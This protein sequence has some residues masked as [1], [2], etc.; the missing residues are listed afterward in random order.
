[1]QAAGVFNQHFIIFQVF[2]VAGFVASVIWI[3]ALAQ[4]IVNLLKVCFTF[5]CYVAHLKIRQVGNK[6]DFTLNI[7]R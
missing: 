3:Y 4:E 5:F 2:A 7:Y 6:L 1:M